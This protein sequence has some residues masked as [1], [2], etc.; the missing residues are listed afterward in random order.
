VGVSAARPEKVE[1]KREPQAAEPYELRTDLSTAQQQALDGLRESGI[2]VTTFDELIGDAELWTE[3]DRDMQ[4]FVARAERLAPSLTQPE[5]KD[6]FLIRR[7]TPDSDGNVVDDP[8]I[9]VD[10][11]WLRF[12]AAEA[13]LDVVNSY[14]GVYTVLTT[15]DNW[16][17]VPFPES[18]KRV[19]SQ[20]WHRDP[21][22]VHVV[23]C[24]LYFSDVDEDAGPF[25]YIPGSADGGPYGEV[26]KWGS[27]KKWY[28]PDELLDER[29]PASARI[30]LTGPK[31]TLILCDTSGFHRG[32]HARAKARVLA[33]LT[34]ISPASEWKKLYH[35]VLWRDGVELSRQSRYALT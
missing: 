4:S 35:E 10:N 27:E 1:R 28:P 26:W 33:T 9:P 12:A 8:R 18:D 13:L 30:R 20:R 29:I 16:Y 11:P 24:F 14:R 2:A 32:G 34:F 3:L 25:E 15:L 19:A 17:T 31:S 22:D 6:Q 5:R 7:W 21:D 23:K